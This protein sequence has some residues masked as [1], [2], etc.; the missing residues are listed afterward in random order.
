MLIIE[1]M[2]TTEWRRQPPATTLSD[3]RIEFIRAQ[4]MFFVATAADGTTANV[5]PKGMDTLR[6]LSDSR[7]AWLN[8]SGSGNETAAH[9]LANGRM[10]LMW[11]S[12]GTTPIIL[13]VYATAT[14]LHPRDDG[15]GELASL[16][17]TFGGSRQIFD[18]SIDRVADSCGTGVPIMT[19]EADRGLTDLEPYYA[20]MSDDQLTGFW[21]RK[22][23]TSNDGLPTGIFAD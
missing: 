14:V 17:P 4:P 2:D 21:T 5:S 16:F 12:I 18:L 10:T 23:T 7:I 11:M 13:R 15:W 1:R 3:P 8:L 19:V 9:V 6:V 20:K 22:N